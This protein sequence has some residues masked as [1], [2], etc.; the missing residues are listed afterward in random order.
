[1]VFIDYQ[2]LWHSGRACFGSPTDPPTFG[3]VHPRRLGELVTAAGASIDPNRTLTEVQVFRGRPGAKSHPKLVSAFSRQVHRWSQQPLVTVR[4]RPVRY[5]STPG[6]GWRAEEKGIDV[7]M[8]LAI[9]LGAREDT[10]DVGVVV[11]ADTDLIPAIEVALAAGRRVETATCHRP[12]GG[13]HARPLTVPG[14][15]LWDHRI[16]LETFNALRDDTNYLHRR[17]Q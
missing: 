8:A 7:L 11:S 13:A 12:D 16:D 5:R 2:N 14:R 4:T 9:A 3:H 6:G 10:Y 15:R 17:Q 1:M